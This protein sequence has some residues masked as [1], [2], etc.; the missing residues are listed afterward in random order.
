MRF[1]FVTLFPHFI[2]PYFEDSILKRACESGC[3]T[4]DI[5]NPRDYSDHRWHKVDDSLQGGGSGMLMTPQPLDS[6]L[7]KLKTHT[8]KL[9]FLDP[10]GKSFLQKDAKRLAKTH[11]LI[12][13][14]GRYEGIDERII[15]IHAD[16]LFSIG[17]YILTGGELPAL[18]MSDAISRYIPGV[19][20]N[21]MSLEEESFEYSLLES[22]SFTKPVEFK[23]HTSPSV[24]SKG[25]HSKI[26]SLKKN[27]SL[28]KTRYYRPD[29][30]K[31]YLFEEP[32]HEK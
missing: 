31:K 2:R 24:L 11:H 17:D 1:S 27:L 13:V 22:P 7:T 15:E 32:T 25:N 23:K 28:Y 6:C 20:G 21:P 9:I 3:I 5:H 26:L 19:L 16:E 29:L 12:F 18:V 30:Y 4:V 14:S 8:S 10:S